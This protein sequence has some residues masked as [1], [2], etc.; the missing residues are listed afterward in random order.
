MNKSAPCS[1]GPF[2][3]QTVYVG[4]A[5][6]CSFG[7]HEDAAASPLCL[8]ELGPRRPWPSWT[9]SFTPPQTLSLINE[10]QPTVLRAG[11]DRRRGTRTAS[12]FLLSPMCSLEEFCRVLFALQLLIRSDSLQ[13][14][15]SS[16]R[17]QTTSCLTLD[18][19]ASV[20]LQYDAYSLHWCRHMIII[21]RRRSRRRI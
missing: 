14:V 3:V 12:G 9:C 7:S 21:I 4:L 15:L 19:K 5:S 11:P 20:I 1:L 8:A 6:I 10:T 17:V 13:F 2:M 16:C 18:T